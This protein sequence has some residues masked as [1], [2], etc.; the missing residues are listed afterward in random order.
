MDIAII[1]PLDTRYGVETNFEWTPTAAKSYSLKVT[2]D[3]DDD[4]DESNEN[5]NGLTLDVIS[6][7]S[8]NSEDRFHT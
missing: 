2:L 3:S 5:N 7:S 8:P 4:I 6:I 1:T